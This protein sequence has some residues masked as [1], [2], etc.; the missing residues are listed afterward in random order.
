MSRTPTRAPDVACG[1]VPKG[2]A[3][4]S[5]GHRPGWSIS[6]VRQ[7]QRGGSQFDQHETLH[8]Q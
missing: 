6:E 1:S 7:P 2:R 5:P 8:R 4:V 3:Y